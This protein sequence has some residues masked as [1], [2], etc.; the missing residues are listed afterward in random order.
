MSAETTLSAGIDPA[1]WF[2]PMPTVGAGL[3]GVVLIL[4]HYMY[5]FGLSFVHDIGAD[6]AMAPSADFLVVVPPMVDAIRDIPH[7]ADDDGACLVFNSPIDNEATD[8]VFHIAEDTHMFGF[9]T[10]PGMEQA[11]VSPRAACSATDDMRERGESFVVSLEL[12][13]PFSTRDDG[14]Y[15]CIANNRWVHLSQ[16]D[17]D[18]VGSWGGFG[19]S[20]VL[21]NHMPGIVTC[22]LVVD[23]AHFEDTQDVFQMRRQRDGDGAVDLSVRECEH[24]TG[25]LDSRVFPDGGPEPF[26][27]VGELCL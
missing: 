17:T 1:A 9:H 19:L 15:G 22:F 8:F 11:L 26:A 16:I 5:S 10:R 21:N 3:T 13:S 23:Q 20:P 6:V 14:S 24:R 18:D 2:M 25:F 27:P 12:M 4:Q 7:I